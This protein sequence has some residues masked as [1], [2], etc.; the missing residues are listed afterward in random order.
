M[1]CDCDNPDSCPRRHDC[2]IAE[3]SAR[4]EAERRA[5]EAAWEASQLPLTGNPIPH[6]WQNRQIYRES[7]GKVLILIPPPATY[8]AENV[9]GA[10]KRLKTRNNNIRVTA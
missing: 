5:R 6:V 10:L 2:G 4:V 7:G 8:H 9:T 3:V 1:T